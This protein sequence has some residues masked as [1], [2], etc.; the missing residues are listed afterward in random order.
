MNNTVLG[1][2]IGTLVL[3]LFGCGVGCSINLKKTLAKAVG[4]NW[5]LVAFG[6]GVAV[7]LGIYSA[8]YFGSPGHLNPAV[9]IAFAIGGLFEWNMVV[10]FVLA[11]FAG[12]FLGAL[13][14]AISFMAHFKETGAD[15]GNSV[16]I[17]A[18]GPAIDA[19]I[20]NVISEIIATFAFIFTLLLLP[21]GDF[22]GGFQ[23]VVAL[24]LLVGISFS[25]GSTTG[26]AINPARDLGPRLMYTLMPLPNKN[27]DYNWKY[28]WVPLVG[29]IVGA[30][31]AVLL[32]NIL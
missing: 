22:P 23:P 4:A 27:T 14:A 8:G 25:F 11:Q 5:V 17:F 24:F 18:T 1:E 6:W 32:V 29:P 10:P 7:M 2:F 3:T 28:A 15:E 26:Y 19:P 13:I 20:A 31:I 9:S 21:A 30:T 16:G 12:A